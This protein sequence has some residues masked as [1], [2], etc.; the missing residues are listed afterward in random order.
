MRLHELTDREWGTASRCFGRNGVPGDHPRDNRTGV[1]ALVWLARTGAVA[2]FAGPL[3][4]VADGGDT[5][6]R[7]TRSELWERVLAELRRIAEAKGGIDWQVHMVDGRACG[8]TAAP[9][10]EKGAAPPSARSQP[11][12]PREQAS[13]TDSTKFNRA[14]S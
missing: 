11:R 10:L 13:A 3:R 5:L 7:W 14:G 12:R 1:D 6:L 9:P 4:P 8:H 2:R